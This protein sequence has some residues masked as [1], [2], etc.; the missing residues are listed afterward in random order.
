L[1]ERRFGQRFH[2]VQ[3]TVANRIRRAAAQE[4]FQLVA[5]ARAQSAQPQHRA[6]AQ[7][8]VSGKIY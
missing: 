1:I 5:I 6:V 2:R 7:E 8:Q 4:G 3:E